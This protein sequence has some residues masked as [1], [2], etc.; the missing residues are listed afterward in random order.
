ME[1]LKK[2]TLII[3][4]GL[5]GCG[6]STVRESFTRLRPE[7]QVMDIFDYIKKY[8]DHEGDTKVADYTIRA[9]RQLFSALSSADPGICATATKVVLF[10]IK[11]DKN[12]Q[13]C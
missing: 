10:I 5:P 6:K 9:H 1:Q 12:L 8:L 11:I 2:R 7:F 13:S 3:L 4:F